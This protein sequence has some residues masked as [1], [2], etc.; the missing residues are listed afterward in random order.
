M[1]K[2]K[3]PKFSFKGPDEKK[4]HD[5]SAKK[6]QDFVDKIGI[7]PN[8]VFSFMSQGKIGSLKNFKDE[9]LCT[10]VERIRS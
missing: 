1:F 7:D 8:H 5:V 9:A 3:A 10:F 2:D 4:I 6:I